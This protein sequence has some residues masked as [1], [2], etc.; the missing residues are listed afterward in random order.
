MDTG[1]DSPGDG[2]A[3]AAKQTEAQRLREVAV[4]R[5]KVDMVG[6]WNKAQGELKAQKKKAQKKKAQEAQDEQEAQKA[7]EAQEGQGEMEEGDEEEEEEQDQECG[8]DQSDE[9]T[10]EE[11]AEFDAHTRGER[12]PRKRSNEEARDWQNWHTIALHALPHPRPTRHPPRN[13]SSSRQSQ[14]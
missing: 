5:K 12:W 8:E 1:A 10:P 9:L 4:R 14:I 7:Q 11:E 13:P 3:A 2:K 6:E